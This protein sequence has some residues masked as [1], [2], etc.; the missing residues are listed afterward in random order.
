MLECSSCSYGGVLLAS[1]VGGI[2]GM[3]ARFRFD[4]Q[5]KRGKQSHKV[6]DM[7]EGFSGLLHCI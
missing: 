4:L 1:E 3:D 2:S 6:D 7:V 5:R